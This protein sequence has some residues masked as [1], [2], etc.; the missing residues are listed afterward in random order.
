M[1]VELIL[2]IMLQLRFLMTC[3]TPS[4]QHSE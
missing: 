1:G 2:T 4:R 3:L